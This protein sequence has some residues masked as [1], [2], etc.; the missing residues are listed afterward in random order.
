[1]SASVA[2]PSCSARQMSTGQSTFTGSTIGSFV[3]MSTYVPVGTESPYLSS[4]SA[5]MA[6][7]NGS[8][9]PEWSRVKTL[10]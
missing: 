4:W 10:S 5:M 6:P 7:R 1:M 9:E 8:A 3:V 2:M